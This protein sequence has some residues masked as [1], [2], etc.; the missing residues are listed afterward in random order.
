MSEV[1]VTTLKDTSGG[2]SSTT[3]QIASGRAKA[4]VN[5]NG[6]GAVAVRASFNVNSITDNGGA[7]DY[8]VNFSSALSSSDYVIL[9]MG[10]TQSGSHDCVI[11]VRGES[12]NVPTTK[13]T[14]AC[15]LIATNQQATAIDPSNISVAVNI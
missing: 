8:T 13:T 15:R 12:N 10:N 6:S 9:A 7:G 2:N 11:G 3:A 1:R 5:F 4:W 14:S